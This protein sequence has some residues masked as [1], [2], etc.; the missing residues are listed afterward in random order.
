MSWLCFE[1]GVSKEVGWRGPR[2]CQTFAAPWRLGG[3]F[4]LSIA[5]GCRI[6]ARCA[7]TG[8][9][10]CPVLGFRLARTAR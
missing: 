2:R 1:R 4:G 10:L 5:K 9:A 8:L 3:S 6:P 7:S